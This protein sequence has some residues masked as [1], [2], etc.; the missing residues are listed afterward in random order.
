MDEEEMR[1]LLEIA[2]YGYKF[3]VSMILGSTGL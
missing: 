3:L 2:S 1:D